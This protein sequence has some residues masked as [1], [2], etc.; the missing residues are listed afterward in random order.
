MSYKM[1]AEDFHKSMMELLE[2]SKQ[3]NKEKLNM[4]IIYVEDKIKKLQ[5]T[6]KEFPELPEPQE[7]ISKSKIIKRG[8]QLFNII[9]ASIE[10]YQRIL[11]SLQKI[12]IK[13]SEE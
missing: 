9:Q 13:N 5:E 10:S 1:S 4:M 8:Y 7:M 3:F 6:I 2:N 12:E 11:I